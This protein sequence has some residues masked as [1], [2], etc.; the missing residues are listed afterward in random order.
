[1][2]ARATPDAGRVVDDISALAAIGVTWVT[3]ALPADTRRDLL[4][5][6]DAFGRD[7]IAQL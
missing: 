6:I 4:Q 1:M 2:F 7:V 3:V 5:E